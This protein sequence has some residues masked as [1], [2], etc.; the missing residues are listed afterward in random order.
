M[1]ICSHVGIIFG[2]RTLFT[3]LDLLVD[4]FFPMMMMRLLMMRFK[5]LLS[6]PGSSLGFLRSR[7]TKVKQML[8]ELLHLQVVRVLTSFPE[9]I[10]DLSNSNSDLTD[11]TLADEDSNS[12]LTD[13]ANRTIRGNMASG[14]T[15]W[16]NFK[17]IQVV[18]PDDQDFN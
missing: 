5:S 17:L 10:Q 4:G 3:G 14:A 9:M 2:T 16:L 12:I 18:L 11:V 1:T 7:S 13:D 8:G 6:S 15:C